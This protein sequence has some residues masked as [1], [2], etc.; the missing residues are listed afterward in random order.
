M[1]PPT[2]ILRLKAHAQGAVQGVGF[3]P[4]LYR[5][6]KELDLN[7]WV[8]NSPQGVGFEVEGPPLTLEK[9]LLRLCVEKPPLCF[10]HNLKVDWLESAGHSSFEIRPSES[11]GETTTLVLPDIACCQD[12]LREMSDPGNRRHLYP[13]TNCTNCG[14]R[15]SIIE[16]LPYDRANTVMKSFPLCQECRREYEDPGNRRFHAQ[17]NACPV[18]GPHLEFQ[19][20]AGA[21]LSCGPAALKAAADALRRG[22]I[23]AVKGVGGFHLM[24]DARNEEAVNTLRLRKRRPEKPFALLFPS[25]QRVQQACRVTPLEER[26]LTSPHAPIVLLQR[27][28]PQWPRGPLRSGPDAPGAGSSHGIAAS[29]APGN[30]N[31][32]VMLPSN[33]LHHV[34][35]GELAFPLVA[36][37][38]NLSGEPVCTDGPES[39]ARLGDIAAFFLTHNR[40]IA[41]PVDDSVVRVMAGREMVLRR[42]RGLAPLPVSFAAATGRHS[43][44]PWNFPRSQSPKGRDTT[45]LA[46]GADLKNSIALAAGPNVFL[47]QHLGDLQTAEANQA[48]EREI[49]SWQNL[50]HVKPDVI[51]A[52]LHPDYFS[53]RFARSGAAPVFGVQHHVAHVL[54]CM[55]DNQ[56]EMP[57]LGVAWDGTGY[58][59]DG[60]LW[61]GEF[62]LVSG[63]AIQ[64]VAH[65][66]P[67]R[68]PGG[69]TAARQP[70]RAALGLLH[71][72]FG[73]ALFDRQ[74]LAPLVSFTGPEKAALQK[75]LAQN[76]HSPQ[77]TSA[78][79]LFDAIAA[80]IGLRQRMTFEG[81]AAMDLEF[82]AATTETEA[83]Y[84]L[85]LTANGDTLQLDWAAMIEL[86]LA[87]IEAGVCVEFIAAK[88]H[89]TLAEGIVTVATRFNR[90]FVVLSGGCFQNQY[91]LE[92]TITRLRQAGFQPFWHHRIP[93]NDGGIALGQIAAAQRAAQLKSSP[94]A[95]PSREKSNASLTP[96]C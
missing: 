89:N 32:G 60:L 59:P 74:K 13:F 90:E 9:F 72:L 40:P 95:S 76:L 19:T 81:Q 8:R 39:A 68:L 96:A 47:S 33:P 46:V 54:S 23:V 57:A 93:T 21:L 7:G 58:G 67:F 18:C 63:A 36:T 50:H 84:P 27:L 94:C 11:G 66:R 26:L 5:L 52:D 41:R 12:C 4:F 24:A 30:P 17:P 14:P 71:E 53:T 44:K 42:A 82:A 25:L 29:V 6:A 31:L 51:A 49:G 75:M 70:R 2:Q 87:E 48:F 45:I 88:F 20:P 86:I 55:V 64:R 79:R 62:F 83:R 61:G 73:P 34:L 35:M 22:E 43:R 85:P 56:L 65:L 15:Y 77:T 91:L 80:I 38:G 69:D 37:S 92:Q 1:K 28:T 16:A 78:G 3:R 10:I